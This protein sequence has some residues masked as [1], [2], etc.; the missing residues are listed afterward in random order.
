MIFG[1]GKKRDDAEDEEGDEEIDYV[2]FQGATNGRE[3]NL[4]ANARLAQAGL[5]P[6][7]ELVTDA[8]LRRADQLRIEP[9]GDRALTHLSIDGVSYPGSRLSKQQGHAVTQMMKLLSGL[10]IQLRQ[11]P[12]SGGIK[13][14]LQ[15]TKYELRVTSTPVAQGSERLTVKIRNLDR[16]PKSADDVGF[17]KEMKER[18][19]ELTSQ[20]KGIIL[21]CG[22]PGSGVSTTMFAVL[23]S[24]DAYQYTIYTVGDIQSWELP[25]VNRF[26]RNEG[27]TLDSCLDR[28]IRAEADV[29][30]IDRLQ[31]AETARIIL[32]RQPDA[33]FITEF[34]APDAISGIAQFAKL[35]GN[36]Q[37]ADGLRAVISQR[38][39]RLLCDKC[40]LAYRPNPKMLAKIGL[41]PETKSLYRAPTQQEQQ[42]DQP[43]GTPVEPCEVCGGSGYFGRTA[44]FELAEMTEG[45]RK[46]VASGAG[47]AE[48]KAQAR[49][50]NMITL[51]HEGLKLVVA[52]KT[53]LEEL[54]R[55]FQPKK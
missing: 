40:K 50:D 8:L 48:I 41:P 16:A 22:S 21:V 31:D 29:I 33:S 54:Q 19:R 11:K 6:T 20:K 27:E 44:M 18:I 10:D 42:T 47:S 24:V 32:K 36:S 5:I 13:A 4:G 23:R 39:I 26:E 51:Q 12:Q 53:S 30:Y 28:A 43:D 1:F 45:L 9:K 38:L 52:G 2:L 37:A 35:V 3:A 17:S 15:G 7:K 25:N 55:I 14:E 49:K 46:V 34:N